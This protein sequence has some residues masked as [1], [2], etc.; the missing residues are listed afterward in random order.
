MKIEE[1]NCEQKLKTLRQ[2]FDEMWARAT[3]IFKLEKKIEELGGD[4]L[5]YMTDEQRA[6]RAE[7]D[8]MRPT[9]F[10]KEDK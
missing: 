3:I 2:A 6:N 10:E 9:L 7:I 1:M 8:K 4:P 5:F